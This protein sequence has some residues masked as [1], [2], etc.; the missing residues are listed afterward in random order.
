MLLL[1][2]ISSS[3]Q[4]ELPNHFIIFFVM[5]RKLEIL[6]TIILSPSIKRGRAQVRIKIL[7]EPRWPMNATHIDESIASHCIGCIVAALERKQQIIIA[8]YINNE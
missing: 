5:V 4:D 2:R 1:N 6:V 7:R 8:P 3:I